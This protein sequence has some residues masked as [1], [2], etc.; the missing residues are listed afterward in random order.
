MT[1]TMYEIDWHYKD[2]DQ[3]QFSH[4]TVKPIT[5]IRESVLPSTRRE[6]TKPQALDILMLLSALESWSFSVGKQLPDHTFD[7]LQET[8]EQ[9][10]NEVLSDADA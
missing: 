8:I 10:R 3:N 1:K 7:K 4:C 5:I 2:S 6:M 9:L